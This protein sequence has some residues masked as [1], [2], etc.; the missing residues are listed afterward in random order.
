MAR[1]KSSPLD[2]IASLPWYV[3]VTLGI[4]AFLLVRGFG[5]ALAPLAWVFLAG[6]W[7]AAAVSF[8][9]SHKRKQLLETQT[10]LDSLARMSWREFEMLVGES[11]RRRG[12][13]VE[14]TGLGGTDG[15][16][17]LVVSKDGR[18]ELVQCKQWRSRR[19][20]ASTVREM[21]GLVDHHQADAVHIVCIGDFTPDA[22]H[23]ARG[24]PIELVTGERLLELVREVQSVP[25][26]TPT[27]RDQRVDPAMQPAPPTIPACPNCGESML[28][29]HNRQ[30]GMAFWGCP[31]YPRCKG[32]RPA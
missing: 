5:G 21:W 4:I 32:T 3:G 20:R 7:L 22:A 30:T 31:T 28:Q 29:R 11:F 9:N 1:R 27:A 14:E 8:L 15:G 10:G 24:K 16:I 6:C 17:D 26:A 19:V 23:F 18:K 13:F 2:E 25:A 12:Y